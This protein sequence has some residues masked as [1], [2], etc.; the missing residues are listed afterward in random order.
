MKQF[1]FENGSEVDGLKEY[2]ASIFRAW[3]LD[4]EFKVFVGCD[5]QNKR[6][7]TSYA[8]C[9][10]F[11]YGT[12]GAHVIHCRDNVRPKIKDR[13]QRL[14]GEVERSLEVAQWL[15]NNGFKVD[16]IDLDFN[17]KEIARSS[18]MVASARGYVLGMGFECD[19][20][21]GMVSAT[22][23]ADHLVRQ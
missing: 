23:A 17:E 22:R 19:V 6:Y 10:V 14:W 18:E 8:T 11:K 9:I 4:K 1:K 2:V 16:R 12:R 5:S 20:K 13:W 3:V 21:P 7:V 15:R